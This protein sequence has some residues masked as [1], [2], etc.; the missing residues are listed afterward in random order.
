[1]AV[2]LEPERVADQLRRALAAA[3]S[4]RRAA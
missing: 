2:R 4:R 1:M 3:E